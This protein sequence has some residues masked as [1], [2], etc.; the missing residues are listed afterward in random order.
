MT[1]NIFLDALFWFFVA[2]GILSIVQ[3]IVHWAL[4]ARHKKE[5]MYVVLTVKNQQDTVEAMIRSIVWQNLHNKNG[6]IIPQIVV[7]D[8]GSQDETPNILK[9]LADDFQFIHITDKQGYMDWIRKM[10][11]Q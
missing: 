3:S 7:V 6:G 5:D 11:N 4:G 9:R 1:G 8:L 2:V 10:V